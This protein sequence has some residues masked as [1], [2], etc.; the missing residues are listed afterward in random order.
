RGHQDI[1]RFQ[2][3]MNDQVLMCVLNSAADLQ[4]ELE[5]IANIQAMLVAVFVERLTMD[6]LHDE[7]RLSFCG[8]SSVDETRDIRMIE[9][10]QDLPLRTEALARIAM[11]RRRVDDLDRNLCG[12]LAI[13]TLREINSACASVAEYRDQSIAVDHSPAQRFPSVVCRSF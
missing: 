7:E 8:F 6:V 4:E 3:A 10:C 5:P 2:I 12:I 11:D 1:G 13:G 9:T